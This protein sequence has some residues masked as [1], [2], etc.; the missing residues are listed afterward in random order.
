MK[1]FRVALICTWCL[2][3]SQGA[4]AAD[5]PSFQSQSSACETAPAAALPWETPAAQ[6]MSAC[7]GYLSWSI[8]GE[9]YCSSDGS[10]HCGG[11][12][13][14]GETPNFQN[15]GDHCD[16]SCCYELEN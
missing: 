16:C 2:V 10:G 5:L 14:T 8:W 15:H 3:G 11:T 7:V 6:P 13:G 1:M 12:C 9:E 4:F